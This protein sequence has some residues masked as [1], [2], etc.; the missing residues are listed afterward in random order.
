MIYLALLSSLLAQAEVPATDA[1]APAAEPEAEIAQTPAPAAE[2]APAPPVVEEPK[3]EPWK[4]SVGLGLI[5]LFGNSETLTATASAQLDKKFGEWAFGAR[6]NG[7]YGQARPASGGPAT[8][9]ETTAARASLLLR[10]DRN[11]ASWVSLFVIGGMET[12]HVKS[13]EL[14]GLGEVGAGFILYERKEG[15]LERIFLRA[16]VGLRASHETRFQYYAAGMVPGG[17]GLPSATMLGPRLGAVIRYA[18]SKDIRFS[19]EAEF[20]PNVLGPSRFL[21]NSTTKLNAR[22][23][24]SL[25]VSGALLVA[26]DSSPAGGK[27][28]TDTAL[29]L[30]LEA[31]F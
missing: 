14:R 17:T 23:T 16:D 18:V 19:E 3:K 10:V 8:E 25:S 29:T 26:F 21:F 11:L 24:Q 27:K 15:D 6:A 7:A 9:A 12:D 2:P 31:A 20:L 22:L 28:T 4:G 13:V 5:A 1:A 30:G